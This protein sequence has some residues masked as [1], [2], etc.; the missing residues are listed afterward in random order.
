MEDEQY[1]VKLV[2]E[3]QSGNYKTPNHRAG[4][5]YLESGNRTMWAEIPRITDEEAK[6]HGFT[7]VDL[8][9]V[10]IFKRVA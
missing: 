8:V 6:K 3:S 9:L 10:E 1:V 7:E 4:M 5:V 2:F